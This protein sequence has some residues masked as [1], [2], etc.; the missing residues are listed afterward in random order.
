VLEVIQLLEREGAREIY[1]CCVHAVLSSNAA[2]RLQ[3]SSLRELVTTDT[4]PLPP[5]KRWPGLTVLSV[6]HLIA[7][8][9]Q[10]IHSGVSVDTIFQQRNHPALG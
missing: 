5:E 9:I 6:S 2:E 4:L 3:N 8:V 10:R 7:E 1:A